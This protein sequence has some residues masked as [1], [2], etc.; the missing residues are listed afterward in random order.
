MCGFNSDPSVCRKGG[1]YFLVTS[2]FT[3]HPSIPIYHSRDLVHWRSIGSVI[4]RP[5]RLPLDSLRFNRGVYA[6]DISYNPHNDTFY[7]VNTCV[8]GIGNFA[9]KCRDP[10][11]GDW[12]DPIPLP[13]AEGIDPRSSST[14]TAVPTSA[15]TACRPADGSG[16][17]TAPS[18]CGSTTSTGTA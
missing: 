6:A 10:F 13:E 18:G 11:A 17:A 16:T 12:S 2:S 7:V 5:E 14:T 4:V 15:T 9:V 1:D 8:D 3:F